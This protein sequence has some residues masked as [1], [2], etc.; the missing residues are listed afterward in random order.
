MAPIADAV[1]RAPAAV[2]REF[3]FVSAAFRVH[4]G[5]NFREFARARVGVE[6]PHTSAICDNYPRFGHMDLLADD[7][8]RTSTVEHD[9]RARMLIFVRKISS[10]VSFESDIEGSYQPN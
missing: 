9:H 10:R 4:Q 7:F 2:R 8:Y 3:A 5:F 6:D 1:E